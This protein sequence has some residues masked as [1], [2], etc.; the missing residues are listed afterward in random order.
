MAKV[1]DIPEGHDVSDCFVRS[2]L[3]RVGD[4]WSL[5]VVI[6][7]VDGEM[8]FSE[9]RRAIP[10]ISQR[11]LTVTLRGLERDGIVAR[12]I[13]AVMPPHIGYSLTPMGESL[14]GA[15][16]NLMQW[17]RTQ[18]PDIEAAQA[19]YDEAQAAIERGEAQR[20]PLTTPTS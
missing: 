13:Y 12:E 2:I 7:L 6:T 14:F 5:Y 16:S 15:V 8:R 11:M 4:K 20:V 10:A 1:L 19:R 17:A 9:L 3:D 18:V